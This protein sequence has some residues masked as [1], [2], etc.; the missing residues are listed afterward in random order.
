MPLDKVYTEFLACPFCLSDL[1]FK[2]EEVRCMNQDCGCGYAVKDGV[3]NMLLADADKP[4]P[5]CQ[6]QRT[7]ENGALK[8]EK[9]QTLFDIPN[10]IS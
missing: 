8:C 3:P 4:C 9:C 2:D 1:T 6:V 7:L 5:K 10:R